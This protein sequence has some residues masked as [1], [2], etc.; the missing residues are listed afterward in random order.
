LKHRIRP[1][2]AR[3]TLLTGA[4]GLISPTGIALGPDNYLYLANQ[5]D[6]AGQGQLIRLN[7]PVAVPEPLTLLGAT[8]A[9]AFGAAVKRRLSS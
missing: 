1:N 3:Q 9:L 4:E 6:G 2:G 5:G 8:A 7:Q